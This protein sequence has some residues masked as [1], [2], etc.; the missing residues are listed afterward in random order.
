LLAGLEDGIGEFAGDLEGS[1]SIP[2]RG[3]TRTM[4]PFFWWCQ[5]GEGASVAVAPWWGGGGVVRWFTEKKKIG[6]R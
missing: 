3:K 5:L 6:G 2:C 4:R 1:G